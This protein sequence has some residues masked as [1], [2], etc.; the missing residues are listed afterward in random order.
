MDGKTDLQR[1]KRG[2]YY[3]CEYLSERV[4]FVQNITFQQLQ[5]FF[6]VAETLNLSETA[7]QLYVSQPA[8]ILLQ[9]PQD[10]TRLVG[11]DAVFSVS[12]SGGV[13]PYTYQWYVI[14]GTRGESNVFAS[15]IAEEGTPVAGAVSSQLTVTASIELNGNQYYCVIQDDIGQKVVSEAARLDV[16]KPAPQTGDQFPLLP[17]LAMLLG[18]GTILVFGY[19]LGKN[20]F[21]GNRR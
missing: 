15:A 14:P 3:R 11:E 6:A 16:V 10:A 20:K 7:N 5:A 13:Q 19:L 8:L 18:C 9:S 12:V 1:G 2:V 17:L 21:L 4:F